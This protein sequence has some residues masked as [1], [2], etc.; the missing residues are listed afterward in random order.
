MSAYFVTDERDKESLEE[1]MTGRDEEGGKA[2]PTAALP[3]S[4][5]P[6]NLHYHLVIN[7]VSGHHYEKSHIIPRH[8]TR[9]DDVA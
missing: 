4:L 2:L 1:K 9:G 8:V 7:T 3:P 6:D 5:S